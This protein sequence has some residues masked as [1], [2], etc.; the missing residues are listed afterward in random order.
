[1]TKKKLKTLFYCL[2]LLIVFTSCS[3]DEGEIISSEVIE[4]E[5]TTT[6][7][8]KAI[9][10]FVGVATSTQ[11]LSD[12]SEYDKIIKREFG[13]ITAEYQMKM[14]RILLSEGNYNWSQADEI[15]D[16]A[17]ANELNIHG[18]TLI[19]HNSTPE[20][21]ENYSGSDAEFENIIEEYITQVVSRY[22]GKI[23]SWD[24]VN[25]GVNNSGGILRSTV[26]KER[27]GDD[28]IA[29]CLNFARNA[30]PDVLL[31]YNDYGM[32]NNLSKQD[33]V[34]E[35]IEDWKNR[36]IPIDGIGFQMHISYTSPTK[37]KIVA[38]TDRSIESGLLLHYSEL[39]VRM[40]PA[41]DISEFTEERS[42]AQK[43][44]FKEVIEIYNAI[45]S[46]NK[47]AITVWGI[48]DDNSWLLPH[49]N[50]Y[51][52]WPLLYDSSFQTKKAYTGF[53][54]GLD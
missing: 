32:A 38:A 35:L 23:T 43:E 53:L 4:T 7:N 15:V 37:E 41:N 16:Y 40:N 12:G 5:P 29:K 54:D 49:H 28:Y 13:S 39:D 47:Y 6:L 36:N 14:K 18:H 51:N 48:K 24:V 25:E 22:K 50:N 42:N 31:F 20:W 46:E 2:T 8:D 19:W 27:M 11:K 26:F 34:F 1:M 3:K 45:P 52:E 10:F 17:V 30:D 21:L 44:K 9:T 33:K